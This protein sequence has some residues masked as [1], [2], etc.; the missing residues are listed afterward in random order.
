MHQSWPLQQLGCQ[1]PWTGVIGV[2]Q[3]EPLTG[4]GNRHS[5]QELQDGINNQFWQQ[6][7]ADEHHPRVG[8]PQADQ[9]KQLPLFIVVEPLDQLDLVSVE[10]EGRQSLEGISSSGK[11]R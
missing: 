7:A 1:W 10:V 5:R 4:M 8:L 2:K 3:L 6:L 9:F 11:F